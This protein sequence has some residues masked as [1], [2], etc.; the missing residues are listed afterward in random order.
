M[1][2]HSL[3][4]IRSSINIVTYHVESGT[5]RSLLEFACKQITTDITQYGGNNFS[6]RKE[7]TMLYIGYGKVGKSK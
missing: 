3:I 7:V 6:D 5:Y 2:K 1:R 4:V